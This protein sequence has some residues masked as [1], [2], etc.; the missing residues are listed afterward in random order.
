MGIGGNF[1]GE[2]QG[3]LEALFLLVTNDEKYNARIRE[4]KESEDSAKKYISRIGDAD[5]IDTL[6][7]KAQEELAKAE[8]V[9]AQYFREASTAKTDAEA[10]AARIISE[11]RA[12]A[13][14]MISEARLREEQSV[15]RKTAMD[16]VISSMEAD[17]A[18]RS[19]LVSAR[20]AS[21]SEREAA[22]S[23]READLK[24]VSAK[25]TE[26]QAFLDAKL[27]A[28]S[29]VFGVSIKE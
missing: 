11:A 1:S 8:A 20:E 25:V 9:K 3:S 27:V 15:S 5:E 17:I 28:L 4:L 18:K 6:K 16:A 19:G 29:E 7:T 24:E 2:S 26:K 10:E 21:L 22:V 14:S 12:S 23:Q 13:E